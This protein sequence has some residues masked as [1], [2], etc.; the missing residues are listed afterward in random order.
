MAFINITDDPLGNWYTIDQEREVILKKT[1][2]P[3]KEG[4]YEF[5]LDI[6][7]AVVVFAGTSGMK[8]S[9]D[10]EL[11]KKAVWDLDWNF[12]RLSI[13]P[14]ITLS[15]NEVIQLIDEALR[16]YGF[17]YNQSNADKISIA[18]TPNV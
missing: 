18:F 1:Y 3:S 4:E 5:E 10:P 9:S 14:E 12:Y 2:G 7:D 16:V 11:A 8:Y 13:P 15:R 17:S 6:Q